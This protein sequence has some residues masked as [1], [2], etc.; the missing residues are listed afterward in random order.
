MNTP[1]Y[2]EKYKFLLSKMKT[3][4]VDVFELD[5]LLNCSIYFQFSKDQNIFNLTDEQ[6]DEVVCDAMKIS[7]SI[8]KM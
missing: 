7:K 1:S 4:D 5:A 2:E 6:K 8:V 3:T